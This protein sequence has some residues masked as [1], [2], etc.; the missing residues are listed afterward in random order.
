MSGEAEA[1]PETDRELE[2]RARSKGSNEQAMVESMGIPVRC[3][4]RK[5]FSTLFQ[6][7][8]DYQVLA[9]SNNWNND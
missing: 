8:T 9:I 4:A 1:M 7:A 2:D 5:T 3:Q 6:K